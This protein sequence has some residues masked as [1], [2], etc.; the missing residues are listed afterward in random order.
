MR[1]ITNPNASVTS[2]TTLCIALLFAVLL[3][4]ERRSGATQENSLSQ[5]LVTYSFLASHYSLNFLFVPR[6]AADTLVRN[7]KALNDALSALH[8]N[9][10]DVL[11]MSHAAV[12]VPAS[13]YGQWFGLEPAK[14]APH[15][16]LL[17]VTGPETRNGNRVLV[18]VSGIGPDETTIFWLE[19]T[20]GAFSTT[21][22][23]DSFKKGKVA[24]SPGT[25]VGMVM[26][27]RLEKD[28]DILLKEWAEPGSRPGIMGEM[29]R[30]FRLDPFRDTLTLV[31]SGELPQ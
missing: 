19:N 8:C 5:A 10:P 7:M 20:K 21:L 18:V 14:T 22:L 2:R 1:P 6:N 16:G 3:V 28:G 23:Y 15:Q 13:A 11:A 4:P 31:S 30:V 17:F 24:N 26:A 25:V 12:V 27:V 9:T 29:N